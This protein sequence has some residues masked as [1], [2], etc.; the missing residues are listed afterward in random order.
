MGSREKAKKFLE[1]SRT[2]NHYSTIIDVA[3]SYFITKAEQ[4][5]NPCADYM[6]KLMS[7]YHE[8]LA[9][10]IDITEGTYADTFSDDELDELIVL[11]GS[12]V[13]AKLRGLTSDISDRTIEKYTSEKS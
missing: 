7:D 8:Q 1:V 12:P 5:G 2:H 11:Y 4:E 10:A 3:L 13:I 6:K 9:G